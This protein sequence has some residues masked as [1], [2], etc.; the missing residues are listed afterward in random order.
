MARQNVFVPALL[1]LGALLASPAE[2]AKPANPDEY[3]PRVG[4]PFPHLVLPSLE[5]GSPL[6]VTSF[7]GKKL[8]LHIWASW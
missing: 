2:P 8:V 5:D 7:R 1:L 4:E 3:E 6:S